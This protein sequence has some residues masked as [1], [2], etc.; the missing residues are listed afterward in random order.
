CDV[1]PDG[2]SQLVTR[3]VLNL[4]HRADH[5]HP[6]PLE[7]NRPVT[8][9]IELLATAWRFAPG[10]RVRLAIAPGDWPTVWPAPTREPPRLFVGADTFLEL[11]VAPEGVPV[12]LA[13]APQ[14]VAF[15]AMAEPE[16]TT[17]RIVHEAATHSVLVEAEG[18]VE[19]LMPDLGTSVREHRSSRAVASEHDPLA[20]SVEATFEFDL[21]RPGARVRSTAWGRYTCT[22]TT[23]RAQL[24]LEVELDGRPFARRAWD[25]ELPRR[26]V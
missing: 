6:E 8:I 10:H 19:R 17:W 20:A 7:P 13:E 24:E 14:R 15:G 26:L 23:F 12:E 5:V 18:G 21:R 4:A 2:C 22:A 1:G 11:P 9:E 25:E 16:D 3:G